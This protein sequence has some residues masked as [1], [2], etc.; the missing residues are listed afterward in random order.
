MVIGANEAAREADLRR[1]CRVYIHEVLGDLGHKEELPCF[2]EQLGSSFEKKPSDS[3]GN[4]VLEFRQ[5]ITQHQTTNNIAFSTGSLSLL[6]PNQSNKRTQ[7]W[8]A[9]SLLG[10]K[11][12]QHCGPNGHGPRRNTCW[13]SKSGNPQAGRGDAGKGK[14]G[15]YGVGRGEPV[16]PTSEGPKG[17]KE[18]TTREMQTRG[19]QRVPEKTV[20]SFEACEDVE[21]RHISIL[22]TALNSGSVGFQKKASA[23][24]CGR[25]HVCIAFR[26]KLSEQPL[27]QNLM[28]ME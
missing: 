25:K 18:K 4:R 5:P 22:T 15:G 8:S 23:S 9:N 13:P 20:F 3:S 27:S 11:K 19:F 14:R 21:Q 16:R 26:A 17:P 1:S 7:T 6:S 12:W 28:K 10:A 24:K 2:S